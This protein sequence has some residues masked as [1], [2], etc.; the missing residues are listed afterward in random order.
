MLRPDEN[1]T[2]DALDAAMRRADEAETQPGLPDGDGESTFGW[3]AQNGTTTTLAQS[4]QTDDSEDISKSEFDLG[5][6]IRADAVRMQ[7]L[8]KHEVNSPRAFAYHQPR[9]AQPRFR[10]NWSA[11]RLCD[12][13]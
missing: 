13:C 7:F 9:L 4:E 5:A 3:H 6:A 10:Q 8:R 12:D 2:L 11:P 1:W